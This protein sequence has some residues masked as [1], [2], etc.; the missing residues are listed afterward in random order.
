MLCL[1][2]SVALAVDFEI[3][4]GLTMPDNQE[5]AASSI[6]GARVR[7]GSYYLSADYSSGK[8]SKATQSFGTLDQITWG[9]GYSFESG[10]MR[11]S[12]EAGVIRGAT[13]YP[14]SWP[15]KE[16]IYY[17]FYPTFGHPPFI[18]HGRFLDLDY[19]YRRNTGQYIKLIAERQVSNNVLLMVTYRSAQQRESFSMWNPDFNGGP[20]FPLE[21]CGCLWIGSNRLNLDSVTVGLV[22][23]F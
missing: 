2:P 11:Y 19:K 22:Y 13:D 20:R 5:L 15:A 1:L 14:D 9:G 6:I 3:F 16:G 8:Q 17:T 12:A 18:T 7:H 10:K 23:R 21:D 4:G